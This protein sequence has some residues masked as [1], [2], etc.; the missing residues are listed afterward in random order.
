MHHT[1][2]PRFPIPGFAAGPKMPTSRL[3]RCFRTAPDGRIPLTRDWPELL[4]R[5]L[6][7]PVTYLQADHVYG[8][9]AL[10]HARDAGTSGSA[11]SGAGAIDLAVSHQFAGWAEAWGAIERCACCGSPGSVAIY[12]PF[13]LRF[14]QISAPSEMTPSEWADVLSPL[15]VAPEDAA[16]R[17]ET[18]RPDHPTRSAGAVDLNLSR[19][20]F[21]NL[22]AAMAEAG[23]AL[24]VHLPGAEVGIERSFLPEHVFTEEGALQLQ[25]EGCGMM[26]DL[27]GVRGFGREEVDG[28]TVLSVFGSRESLLLQLTSAEAGPN[29]AH[30]SSLL[31]HFVSKPG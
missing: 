19:H 24:R 12:N 6:A 1:S 4:D 28:C 15:A 30:W 23:E 29:G 2:D 13:G 16:T 17:S 27:R 8:R 11:A 14:F 26:L 21:P 20:A 10:R 18:R 3:R 22:L 5:L 9:M 7:L 25:G 31:D